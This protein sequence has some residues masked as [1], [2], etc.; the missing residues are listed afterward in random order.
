MRVED[1]SVIKHGGQRKLVLALVLVSPQD[2]QEAA[3]LLRALVQ[4][5][6]DIQISVGTTKR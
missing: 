4:K 1:A 5:R 3:V 2:E 6:A